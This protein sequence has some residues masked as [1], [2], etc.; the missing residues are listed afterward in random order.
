VSGV[1]SPPPEECLN[2]TCAPL[3]LRVTHRPTGAINVLPWRV[4][5]IRDWEVSIEG[6]FHGSPSKPYLG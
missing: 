4:A 2:D 3:S 1:H 5:K 6:D